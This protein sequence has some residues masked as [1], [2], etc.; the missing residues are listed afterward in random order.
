M[1]YPNSQLPGAYAQTT[2]EITVTVDP[3]FLEEESDPNTGLYFWAYHVV[4]HNNGEDTVQLLSRYW[5][6][7]NALGALQEVR[8]DGVVGEQ[9]VLG[10]GEIFE[11]TSGTPLTTSSGF[12]GGR[13]QM[14]SRGG[15]AFEVH[16]PTF[17][18]DSPY[19]G[20]AVN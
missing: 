9:P 13:Y 15:Q 10:P 8:G 3:V 18:L 4:I 14:L 7:T 11:Y 1:P 19:E 17:S 2:R 20:H 5:R 16:I 6:I 12:M